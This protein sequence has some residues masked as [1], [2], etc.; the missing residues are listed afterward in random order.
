M[1]LQGQ[2][3]A[4]PNY[5]TINESEKQSGNLLKFQQEYLCYT[6]SAVHVMLHL[7][8]KNCTTSRKQGKT[9]LL[10]T[11][12]LLLLLLVLLLLLLL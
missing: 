12:L 5:C 7:Q 1:L 10:L 4:R 2:S 9:I 8:A 6:C 11:L 3:P